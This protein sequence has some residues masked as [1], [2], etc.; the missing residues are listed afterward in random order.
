MAAKSQQEEAERRREWKNT[1]HRLSERE[2]NLD[3]KLDQLGK[4]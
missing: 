4:N 1:E 3:N 2:A